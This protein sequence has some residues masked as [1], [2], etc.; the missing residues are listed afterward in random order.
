MALYILADNW[1]STVRTAA[2]AVIQHDDRAPRSDYSQTT[3]LV[4]TCPVSDRVTMRPT[5]PLE[6]AGQ[7]VKLEG[8]LG[9]VEEVPEA[10]PV[11]VEPPEVPPP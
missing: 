5:L 1:I 7:N 4:D 3:E 8:P 6:P 10:E 11:P 9:G 2:Q